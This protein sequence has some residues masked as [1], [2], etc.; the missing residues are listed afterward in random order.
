MKNFFGV[1]VISFFIF[2][3]GFIVITYF[4]AASNRADKRQRNADYA[5]DVYEN[6]PFIGEGRSRGRGPRAGDYMV[7]AIVPPL[8]EYEEVSPPARS[9]RNRTA[10]YQPQYQEQEDLYQKERDNDWYN[11]PNKYALRYEQHG[12]DREEERSQFRREG[13]EG[14]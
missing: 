8:V 9:K 5:V 11:D 3:F 4:V 1:K 13:Y 10:P 7:P 6:Q 12:L 2:F 14:S